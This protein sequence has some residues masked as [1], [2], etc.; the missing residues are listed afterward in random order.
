MQEQPH[1]GDSWA[2]AQGMCTEHTRPLQAPS[3]R[4]LGVFIGLGALQALVS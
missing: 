4:H 1:G 3:A 2:K